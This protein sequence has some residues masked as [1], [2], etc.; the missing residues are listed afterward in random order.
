[1]S[2][3][4]ADTI[5]FT[6][7]HSESSY[8][9]DYSCRPG[10]GMRVYAGSAPSIPSTIYKQALTDGGNMIDWDTVTGGYEYPSFAFVK[11]INGEVTDVIYYIN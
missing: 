2:D 5:K 11:T 4:D 3:T 7:N 6:L 1:M 8:I 10:K 9:Y